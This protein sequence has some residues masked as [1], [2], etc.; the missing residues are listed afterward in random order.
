[1]S[2]SL[3]ANVK[4]WADL[5]VDFCSRNEWIGSDSLF[6]LTPSFNSKV[7]EYSGVIG[8]DSAS[9]KYVLMLLTTYPL[10]VIFSKLPNPLFKNVFSLVVGLW[11]MQN[12]FLGQWI[13][14]LITSVISYILMLTLPN[15]IMPQTVFVFLLSYLSASHIYCMYVNYMG[16]TLDFT[17]PQMLITMKLSMLA[18]NIYDGRR[19]EQL[20]TPTKNP[21]KDSVNKQRMKFAI[22]TVPN[23]LQYFAYTYCFAT[24]LA[25][26][27]FEYKGYVD[28]LTGEAYRTKTS[29]GGKLRIPPRAGPVLKKLTMGLLCVV[30]FQV[31]TPHFPIGLIAAPETIA[32][33][34]IPR[35]VFI[36]FLLLVVRM[37]YYFAWKVTDGSAVLCGFGYEGKDE[38][39]KH[40]WN[41]VETM[42]ILGFEFAENMTGNTRSWNKMAQNW[43]EGYVYSRTNNSLTATYFVSAFWHGFYPGYY[44]FFMSLPLAQQTLRVAR[45]NISPHFMTNPTVSSVYKYFCVALNSVVVNYMVIPFQMLSFERG[46]LV[47]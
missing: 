11:M 33:P 3:L 9:F 40:R 41:G 6:M 17:G 23:P 30:I 35:Y 13:H 25:G 14:S 10:A 16:W 12:I 21:K 31:F 1:M 4:N 43:L 37:K 2:E 34:F 15:R 24:V 20:Q 46:T 8:M 19:I 28:A 26:P 42:D 36:W 27:A 44:F 5:F 32:M 29:N 22:K 39:G 38:D 47:W 45:K 18:Y 7:D